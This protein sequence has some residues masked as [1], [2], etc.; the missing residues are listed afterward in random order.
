MKSAFALLAAIGLPLLLPAQITPHAP[1]SPAAVAQHE[2]ER[3]TTL[4]TL[5]PSQ[6]EQ[7]TALFTTEATARQAQMANARTA[8]KELETAIEANDTAAIQSA[9]SSLGQIEGANIAA[10]ALAR[11]Q[12]YSL[13]TADQKTRFAALEKD[14]MMGGGPG[15]GGRFMH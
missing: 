15:P 11:A 3:Y 5:N 13:L 4:L 1:P 10:H 2:V 6:V 14:H 9:A 7:A 12:F 8:R